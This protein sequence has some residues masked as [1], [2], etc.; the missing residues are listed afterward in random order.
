[1]QYL[2]VG[3]TT[4]R[5]SLLVSI[6]AVIQAPTVHAAEIMLSGQPCNDLCQAWMGVKPYQHS[7]GPTGHVAAVTEN[8]KRRLVSE[9]P[10]KRLVDERHD[11]GRPNSPH[12][13]KI[14]AAREPLRATIKP[15]MTPDL[16]QA[17]V[18]SPLPPT[19]PG[20]LDGADVRMADLPQSPAPV[21]ALNPVLPRPAD[22]PEPGTTISGSEDTP[23]IADHTR[24]GTN[25]GP[26]REA[27]PTSTE[28]ADEG[29]Q[30]RKADAEDTNQARPSQTKPQDD[31][32]QP[33]DYAALNAPRPSP[34]PNDEVDDSLSSHRDDAAEQDGGVKPGTMAGQGSPTIE[35]KAPGSAQ[36]AP[37]DFLSVAVGLI[38]T[39]P[40]GT[41]VHFVL[42][43]NLNRPAKNVK[44]ACDA[45]NLQG[46]KVAE[47]SVVFAGVERSDIAFGQVVFPSEV[48]PENSRFVCAA[49][50]VVAALDQTR[51]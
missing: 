14:S 30:G 44:V 19:R 3:R 11:L 2:R 15:P 27:S 12:G 7:V 13:A 18:Y 8:A 6:I 38:A 31:L 4:T 22:P 45:Q 29:D 1:M 26:R 43:N 32:G 40:R 39:D 16:R 49:E 20:N 35:G 41:D 33:K 25:P 47:A 34:T 36:S 42:I 48:E 51:P 23:A 37:G 50:E 46:K 28:T 9:L 10:K 24:V 21:P 17:R 5:I